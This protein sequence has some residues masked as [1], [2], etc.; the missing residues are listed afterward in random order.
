[1]VEIETPGG[2]HWQSGWQHGYS[3][4]LPPSQLDTYARFGVD[5]GFFEKVK[6][7]SAKLHI[8]FALSISRVKEI[9]HI[10]LPTGEFT[11]PD[12]ALC[13]INSY[14]EQPNN[15][16]CRTAGKHSLVFVTTVSEETTCPKRQ[17][18]SLVPRGTI[19]FGSQQILGSQLGFDPVTFFSI[20]VLLRPEMTENFRARLCPGTPLMFRTLEE[21][22]R[23]RSE[24]T[25]DSIRL[26]DYQL[27]DS[28]PN[29][30]GI[31][32]AAQ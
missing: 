4:P 7:S 17:D 26:A 13:S 6:S 31:G 8:W 15:L 24:L 18:E 11:T 16:Q 19:F 22:Q 9:N 2:L 28:R 3:T 5:K 29:T 23:T 25:I 14:E 10:V 21:A 12:G 27:E 1:M 32:I 30:T 20:G